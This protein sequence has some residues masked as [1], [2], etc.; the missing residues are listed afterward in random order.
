MLLAGM[1]AQNKV[2]RLEAKSSLGKSSTL[3]S[4]QPSPLKG[5]GAVIRIATYCAPNGTP[6]LRGMK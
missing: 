6:S 5:E 2:T 4:P 1:G 3:P